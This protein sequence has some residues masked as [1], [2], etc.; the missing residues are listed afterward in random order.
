L[1][2]PHQRQ[3][4]LDLLEVHS[5]SSGVPWVRYAEVS[6]VGTSVSHSAPSPVTSASSSMRTPPQPARYT[7][8]SIVNTMPG[9]ATSGR[10][11]VPGSG[12]RSHS[13]P[14]GAIRGAS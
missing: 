3:D 8:G 14:R 1:V 6:A 13:G 2:L 5:R 12:G 11:T 9:A 4:L 10:G 7:P